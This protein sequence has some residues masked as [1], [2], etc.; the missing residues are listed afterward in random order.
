MPIRRSYAD[1]GDACA[2]AHA[3][4][5]MGDRWS[6]IVIRE[7]MLGPKRFGELLADTHGATASVVALRLRELEQAGIVEQSELPPPSRVR[8]YQLTGW[9]REFEPILQSLGRWAQRSPSLS[10]GGTLTPDASI[11]AMRTMAGGPP[12]PAPLSFDLGLH[13]GRGMKPIQT[14]F[15]ISWGPSPLQAQK[16]VDHT[17]SSD[18]IACD[19]AIW[20]E[21]LFGDDDPGRLLDSD[22]VIAR[23]DGRRI[24]TKF[25]T[26]FR[27]F[28]GAAVVM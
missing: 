15:H 25:L 19:S 23:G 24:A 17:D 12:P 20:T 16:C 9:G 5:L 27:K 4:D 26:R 10:S 6:V 21:S 14:W 18:A 8:V 3:L 7:L 1:H 28:S 13:D 22:A 11:L 2:A